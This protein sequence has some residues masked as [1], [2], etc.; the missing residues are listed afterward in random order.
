MHPFRA[1]PGQA[2]RTPDFTGAMQ[3]LPK[4]PKCAVTPSFTLA[5]VHK[6]LTPA[7]SPGHPVE[8]GIA[9]RNSVDS[10]ATAPAGRADEPPAFAAV[11]GLGL[12][13][14]QACVV[15]QREPGSPEALREAQMDRDWPGGA[16]DGEVYGAGVRGLEPPIQAPSPLGAALAE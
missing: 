2:V 6:A 11:G 16:V 1:M 15:G 10:A 8:S 3:N 9:Y 5:R 4:F 12:E 14:P 7:A 13:E